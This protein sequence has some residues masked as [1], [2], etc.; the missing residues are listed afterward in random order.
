MPKARSF[1][2]KVHCKWYVTICGNKCDKNNDLECWVFHEQKTKIPGMRF[3]KHRPVFNLDRVS[4]GTGTNVKDEVF[5]AAAFA[6]LANTQNGEKL[7]A[8]HI[9]HNAVCLN[10][11]HI[12]MEPQSVNDHRTHCGGPTH[13]ECHP[14]VKCL[15][16]GTKYRQNEVCMTWDAEKHEYVKRSS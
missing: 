8:S 9:C 5:G 16:A 7:V 3:N 12:V 13:C 6:I 11:A 1:T 15:V 2:D 10:P 14:V 4:G